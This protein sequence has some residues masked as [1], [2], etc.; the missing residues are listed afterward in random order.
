[1][2][3]WSQISTSAVRIQQAM[4]EAGIKQTDL[5]EATGLNKS[6]IS[7]Y[8][9]GQV[10]PKQK[11]IM[12]LAQALDVSEMW[13][14]GYDVPKERI[15]VVSPEISEENDMA[16]QFVTKMHNNDAFLNAVW[17]LAQMDDEQLVTF[18]NMDD[19]QFA[20]FMKLFSTFKKE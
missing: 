8:L 5:A 4:S 17:R 13:L 14:W 15:E 6:T 12:T 20:A 18:N 9:S 2:G 16:V 11:A 1:M 10:E 3:E 7:R 19:E